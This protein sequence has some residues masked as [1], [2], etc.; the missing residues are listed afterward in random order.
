MPLAPPSHHFSH[1]PLL[2]TCGSH[3]VKYSPPGVFEN[4]WVEERGGLYQ[5]VLG[6]QDSTRLKTSRK[7]LRINPPGLGT[8]S[9]PSQMLAESG[10]CLDP[11]QLTSSARLCAPA[12]S[13][14]SVDGPPITMPSFS[15][16]CKSP[17]SRNIAGTL[18]SGSQ[19][20]GELHPALQEHNASFAEP[21]SQ[22][23]I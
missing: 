11:F 22:K 4:A 10:L 13:H 19:S 1:S 2:S 6:G 5:Q 7:T 18:A 17:L 21:L 14:L 3:P 20:A 9:S 16:L 12:P 23:M 15:L 8:Q